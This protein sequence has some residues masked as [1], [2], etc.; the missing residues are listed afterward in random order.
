MNKITTIKN[1][2]YILSIVGGF[3]SA[4]FFFIVGLG[5]IIEFIS[6]A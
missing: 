2:F 3:L 5:L 1:M 6:H 4:L